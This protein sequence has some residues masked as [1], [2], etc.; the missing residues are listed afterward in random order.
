M[1][2]VDQKTLAHPGFWIVMS[3]MN[4]WLANFAC[5]LAGLGLLMPCLCHAGAMVH[6]ADDPASV[7]QTASLPQNRGCCQAP[8][9]G[10]A[11]HPSSRSDSPPP[12]C[13]CELGGIQELD[14]SKS[15]AQAPTATSSPLPDSSMVGH[16]DHGLKASTRA[17]AAVKWSATGVDRAPFSSAHRLCA[18]VC[19]WLV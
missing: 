15:T 19:R 13:C 7:G 12:P 5:C 1:K 10:N 14:R 9:G 18:V 16:A 6:A 2:I 11:G 4:R 8:S 3:F 17:A